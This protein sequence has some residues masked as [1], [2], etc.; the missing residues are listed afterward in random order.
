MDKIFCEKGMTLLQIIFFMTKFLSR[1]TK[2]QECV[3]LTIFYLD[4]P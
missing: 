2:N 3:M 4:Y 1:N